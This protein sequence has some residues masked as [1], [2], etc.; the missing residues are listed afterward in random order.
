MESDSDWYGGGWSELIIVCILN[1]FLFG[2]ELY[3]VV[4]RQDLEI[5]CKIFKENSVV[6][7]VM[8]KFGLILFMVV[9]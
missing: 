3:K 2:V 4:F 6:V 7:E 5:V 9:V 1:E 8:D